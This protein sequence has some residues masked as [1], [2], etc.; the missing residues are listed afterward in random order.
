MSYLSCPEFKDVI[1]HIV[2]LRSRVQAA[3]NLV[4]T[5]AILLACDGP[6]PKE[7]VSQALIG[8]CMRSVCVR[9]CSEPETV[10]KH[11]EC[12]P[13]L[14]EAQQEVIRRMSNF[15]DTGLTKRTKQHVNI[16]CLKMVSG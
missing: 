16:I 11:K 10:F 1:E 5:Q 2:Q 13:Y 15:D 14:Q 3:G 7:M 6:I 9:S 8:A 4:F 12:E